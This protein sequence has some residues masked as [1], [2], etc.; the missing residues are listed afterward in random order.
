[1]RAVHLSDHLA[2]R[3]GVAVRAVEPGAYYELAHDMGAG[4]DYRH[5]WDDPE[6]SPYRRALDDAERLLDRGAPDATCSPRLWQLGWKQLMASTYEAGW[7][8]AGADG[9]LHPSAWGKATAAHACVV[10][11]IDRARRHAA[12][13]DSAASAT[14]LDVDGDGIDEIVLANQ[15]LY[16]VISPAFGA[17]VVHL[18]EIDRGDG[19][20]VV[21]NPADD[22]HLQE[23]LNACMEQPRSHIGAFADEGGEND[24]YSLSGLADGPAVAEVRLVSTGSGNR[25]VGAT[26]TFRLASGAR[27]LSVSYEVSDRRPLHHIDFALSPDYL[28]LLR[29]GRRQLRPVDAPRRRG[30]SNG[31]TSVWVRLPAREPVVWGVPV[32]PDHGH[33][34]TLRVTAYQRAFRLEL[35]VGRP[36]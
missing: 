31:A 21:G 9:R 35:G 13:G 32:V 6:W 14:R 26:K 18:F 19:V 4:E 16:A 8:V 29:D 20:L 24:P 22:W 11:V 10:S 33:A 23:D 17:R 2:E 25:S 28:S 7:Q 1:V 30:W 15:H 3:A 36:D 27:T 12:S 34:M 5:W